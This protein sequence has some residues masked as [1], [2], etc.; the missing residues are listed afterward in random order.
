MNRIESEFP[1]GVCYECLC[2]HERVRLQH[3]VR[4]VHKESI[5]S[6]ACVME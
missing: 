1:I 3:H 5:R 4:L 6:R 2:L